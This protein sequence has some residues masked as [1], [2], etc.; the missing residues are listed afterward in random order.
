MCSLLCSGWVRPLGRSGISWIAQSVDVSNVVCVSDVYCFPSLL[1]GFPRF[2]LEVLC[3][4][5]VVLISV[6]FA[7]HFHLLS[8]FAHVAFLFYFINETAIGC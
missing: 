3:P 1:V 4:I 2:V 7:V 5:V 8:E 6:H